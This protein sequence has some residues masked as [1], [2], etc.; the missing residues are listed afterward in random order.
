M[1]KPFIIKIDQQS[2]KF[3]LEQRVGTL[4]QQKWITR[5][6]GYSFLVEYKKGDKN[7]VADAFSRKVSDPSSSLSLLE[8]AHTSSSSTLSL[9][10]P[11][12]DAQ[13]YLISFP[14]PTWLDILKDSYQAYSEYHNLLTALATNA[15]PAHL[16]S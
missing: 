10:A 16:S 2:L 11:Q 4:A 15:P 9:A 1:G 7:K 14:C 3:L 6:L 13:F 8:H 5:F 12:D